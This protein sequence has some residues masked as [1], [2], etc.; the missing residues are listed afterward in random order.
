MLRLPTADL[1]SEEGLAELAR[2]TGIPLLGSWDENL[3]PGDMAKRFP[4]SVPRLTMAG[5]RILAHPVR[6]PLIATAVTFLSVVIL[7]I[8]LFA[9]S[10]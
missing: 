2:R 6:T 5:G 4:G 8:L 7:G 9:R 3:S 10:K 1:I